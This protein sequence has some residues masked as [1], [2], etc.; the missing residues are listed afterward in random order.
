MYI[1]Y[2]IWLNK[3]DEELK[4]SKYETS[5]SW[6]AAF[7][8]YCQPAPRNPSPVVTSS[9]LKIRVKVQHSWTLPN[10]CIQNKPFLCSSGAILDP[11]REQ[12]RA[13]HPERSFLTTSAENTVTILHSA[14]KNS[15]RGKRF[16]TFS[17]SFITV[18]PCGT[19]S[20]FFWRFRMKK[21]SREYT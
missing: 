4:I 6:L 5:S 13:L 16:G 20:P 1:Q 11:T 12:G 15:S 17:T 3:T 8:L 9:F 10:S 19:V 14:R 18:L 21:F 2:I 7:A